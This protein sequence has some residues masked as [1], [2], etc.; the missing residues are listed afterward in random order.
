MKNLRALKAMSLLLAVMLSG[1]ALY[2]QSTPPSTSSAPGS[3]HSGTRAERSDALTQACSG[4]VRELEAARR[5][6]DLLEREN[7]LLKD[8]LET[9][10]RTSALL[11]ELNAARRAEAE[12]LRSALAASSKTLD[13][14]DEAIAA[15]RKLID[16]LRSKRS[17]PWKRLGDFLMGVAAGALVR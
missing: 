12:A 3:T 4:A 6:T 1:H 14:K 16:S 11:A 9:E 8:R 7:A 15:Q 5:L 13:A 10:R 2:G 17:S